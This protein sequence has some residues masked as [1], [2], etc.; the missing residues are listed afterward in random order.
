MRELSIWSKNQLGNIPQR[1]KTFEKEL[2]QLSSS[3][4]THSPPSPALSKRISDTR[5]QLEFLY[6]CE[7]SYWEER[8]KIKWKTDS[9][10]GIV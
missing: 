5:Q 6:D 1:I 7:N 8:A 4:T 3:V 2:Q 9:V 10:L